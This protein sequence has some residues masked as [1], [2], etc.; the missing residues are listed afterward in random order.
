METPDAL[1]ELA[2]QRGATAARP[3]AAGTSQ[4]VIAFVPV[5]EADEF[6]K[7]FAK[8]FHALEIRPGEA[9]RLEDQVDNA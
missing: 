3:A 2:L 9:A 6:A 4:A 1:V 7:V 5:Q 8:D